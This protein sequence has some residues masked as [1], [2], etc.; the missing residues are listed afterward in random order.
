MA[1]ETFIIEGVTTTSAF[2]ARVMEHPKFVAGDIDTKFL[3]REP[4]LMKDPVAAAPA[5][6]TA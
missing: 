2:L 1:L 4:E 3:E 5:K 6:E